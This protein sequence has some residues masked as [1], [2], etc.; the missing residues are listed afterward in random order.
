MYNLYEDDGE[1]IELSG[2]D[3]EIGEDEGFECIN[4]GQ[5]IRDHDDKIC[6]DQQDMDQ[7]T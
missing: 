1:P 4:C 6:N 3:A 2:V 5:D 7:L